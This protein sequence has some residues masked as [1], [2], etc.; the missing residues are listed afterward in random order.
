M[1]SRT[2]QEPPLVSP[3]DDSFA[4]D[5]NDVLQEISPQGTDGDNVRRRYL[6]R[7]FW[8]SAR[9]FWGRGGPRLAWPLSAAIMLIVVLNLVALYGINVW[10]RGI[11]DALESAT[12]SASLRSL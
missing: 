11:F 7:R 2:F 8:K 9:G 3:G 4:D 12:R 10:N 6:V 5:T 1:D